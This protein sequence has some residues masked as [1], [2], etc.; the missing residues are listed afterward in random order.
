MSHSR[1]I[2]LIEHF[3]PLPDPR[4]AKKTRH[5]LIDIVVIAI[6]AI[7]CGANDYESIA[8]FGRSKEHWFKSFLE[9]PNGIPSHDTFNRVFQLLSP[10]AFQSCFLSWVGSISG[11]CCH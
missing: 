10:E 5:K 6:C 4:I 3:R 9:L 2:S 7:I 11:I 1:A 8:E